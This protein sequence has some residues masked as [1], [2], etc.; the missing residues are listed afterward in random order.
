M[1]TF[2]LVCFGVGAGYIVISFFLGELFGLFD[3]AADIDIGFASP[4]KPSVIASFLIV[5]GGLGLLLIKRVNLFLAISIALTLACIV[6]FLIFRY[7]IV[8]LTRAQNTS[9]VEKQS[10]I[11]SP[12]LVTVQIPQG[13][14]GKIRYFAN[15]NTYSAPAKSEDGNE[16][17]QNEEVII[18]YIERNTYYVARRANSNAGIEIKPPQAHLL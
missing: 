2:F 11:G 5:F 13:K 8:P 7:V 16:L 14:F 15:G 12:A 6:S 1:D 10:L 3:F 4:L 17:A 9:A 18:V